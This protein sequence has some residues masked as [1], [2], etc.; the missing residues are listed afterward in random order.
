MPRPAT[1]R[2]RKGG[3]VATWS[4][5]ATHSGSPYGESP[6]RQKGPTEHRPFRQ[7]GP[8]VT[9]IRESPDSVRDSARS[10]STSATA[11]EPLP[12]TRGV[13]P[14]RSLFQ[15][16][17]ELVQQGSCRFS[18]VFRSRVLDDRF[19]GLWCRVP[20]AFPHIAFGGLCSAVC[21]TSGFVSFGGCG[22]FGSIQRGLGTIFQLCGDFFQHRIA[23]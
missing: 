14:E 1:I 17:V 22:F 2:G 10:L 12:D 9:I 8:T 19:D 11:K 15:E 21:G 20:H 5:C 23:V 3:H 4:G 13:W 7:K 16:R 6:F 18:G